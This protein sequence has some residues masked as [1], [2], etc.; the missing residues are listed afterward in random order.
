[1]L[2]ENFRLWQESYF[3]QIP[4][5]CSNMWYNPVRITR[6][7]EHT[8]ARPFLTNCSANLYTLN[9]HKNA[10]AWINVLHKFSAKHGKRFPRSINTTDWRFPLMKHRYS[11]W[12]QHF[13]QPDCDS[14][15]DFRVSV[16]ILKLGPK[17][18]KKS[19]MCYCPRANRKACH[20]NCLAEWLIGGS[21][22]TSWLI[23]PPAIITRY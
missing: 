8:L 21:P 19:T 4:T 22:T 18:G 16:K 9:C 6:T 12:N 14:E 11:V 3:R 1:M 20:Q 17:E 2:C 7:N 5:T 13:M 15:W 10:H 23:S